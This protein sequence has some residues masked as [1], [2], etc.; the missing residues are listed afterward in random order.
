MR[1]VQP[2]R[3]RS[4]AP[5]VLPED[6][7]QPQLL[8]RHPRRTLF[9]ILGSVSPHS[10]SAKCNCDGNDASACSNIKSGEE[11]EDIVA[12][13]GVTTDRRGIWGTNLT[14]PGNLREHTLRTRT[15][16]KTCSHV[17]RFTV[18]HSTLLHCMFVCMCVSGKNIRC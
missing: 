3:R 10:H 12:V 2:V 7:L 14:F 11:G 1:R 6:R 13:Y 4:Q 15:P 8:A 17:F 16:G 5:P 9:R 18:L